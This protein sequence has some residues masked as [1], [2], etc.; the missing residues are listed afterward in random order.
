M[1]D[2]EQS[3]DTNYNDIDMHYNEPDESI[4]APSENY[5]RLTL[6]F[7]GIY[8]SVL[9][10]AIFREVE[11]E[12]ENDDEEIQKLHYS[13]AVVNLKAIYRNIAEF[14]T[15]VLGFKTAMY[16]GAYSPQF[17]NY[18]DDEIYAW[19]DNNELEML[20]QKLAVDNPHDL[21][22]VMASRSDDLIVEES[23]EDIIYDIALAIFEQWHDCANSRG[24]EVIGD[25][26]E[27]S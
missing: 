14:T 6:P 15:D 18:C 23:G 22:I 4:P 1:T 20:Y 24:Y 2:E 5:T 12:S 17:Y 25:N 21:F 7:V 16:A 9:D 13:K 8:N 10:D 26:I 11:S 27:W 19:V 3:L